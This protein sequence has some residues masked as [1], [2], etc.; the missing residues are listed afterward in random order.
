MENIFDVA[1]YI[2]RKLPFCTDKQ[3]QKITYYA[4]CWFIVKNNKDG[5]NITNRLFDQQ[6]QAWIHGPVFQ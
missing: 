5:N 3:I 6:P 1:I 2:Y 4:Y